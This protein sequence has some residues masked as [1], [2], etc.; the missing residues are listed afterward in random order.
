MNI[1]NDVYILA[2]GDITVITAPAIQVAFKNCAPFTK[3]IT[4]IDKATIDDAKNLDLVM[5]M[6]NLMEYSS[7]YSEIT[8]SFCFYSKDE[9]TDFINNMANTDNSKSFKYRV[10]LLGNR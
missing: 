9:A 7:N 4:E 10:K 5:P 2:R 3:C 1:V 8:E 6:Y